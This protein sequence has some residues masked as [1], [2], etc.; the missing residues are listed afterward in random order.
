MASKV[1]K[2]ACYDPCGQANR[3]QHLT[4]IDIRGVKNLSCAAAVEESLGSFD[5]LP[6]ANCP[7]SPL[8][9]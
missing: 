2:A 6:L 3:P 1:K 7:T 5:P 4:C 9:E 8:P